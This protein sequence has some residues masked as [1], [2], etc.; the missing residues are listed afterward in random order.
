MVREIPQELLEYIAG[1]A[2]WTD[3]TPG[4]PPGSPPPPTGGTN[5]NISNNVFINLNSVTEHLPP[6]AT[7]PN[8]TNITISIGIGLSF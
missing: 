3:A 6:P 5:I 4:T 8:N 7:A 2:L 1:A